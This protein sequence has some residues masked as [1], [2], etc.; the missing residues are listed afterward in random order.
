MLVK[1][2][3]NFYH[4]T[5]E[6]RSVT[7]SFIDA[8]WL[9][10]RQWF[11]A[12]PDKLFEGLEAGGL[13]FV[14]R[15][16][17]W[18]SIREVMV[19]DEYGVIRRVL[20]GIKCPRIVDGGANIGLVSLVVFSEF[21][22]ARV[23]SYEASAGTFA[24]LNKN[25]ELNSRFEW[26]VRQAALWSGTETLKFGNLLWST[27][28]RIA[29][30]SESLELVKGLPLDQLLNET[31][32]PID[33]MKLDI[34]GAEEQFLCSAAELLSEVR[35]LLIELHPKIANCQRVMSVIR[36]RWKN[37]YQMPGRGTP[38]PLILA[39]DETFDMPRCNLVYC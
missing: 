24:I 26:T 17:D 11:C 16:R 18:V 28:S 2:I 4:V 1:K 30:A 31:G 8:A 27:S 36:G 34:E 12:D 10:L 6:N 19:E 39:S 9:G 29:A 35:T 21:P 32:S 14:A 22:K 37:L 7:N 25:R 23:Y 5:L 20:S 33:L 38:N 15:Y 3:R 13:P